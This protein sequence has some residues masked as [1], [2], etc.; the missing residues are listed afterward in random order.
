[1]HWR[2]LDREHTQAVLESVKSAAEPGLFS[3]ATSEVE[4]SLLP[5]YKEY[6]A[7][8]V[9]NYAS[10]PSFTFVYLGDGSFFHF[11]DGS[12][13]PIFAVNDKGQLNLTE[14]NVLDYLSFYFENVGLEDGEECYFIQNPQDMPLF[15]SLDDNTINAIIANHES[16]ITSF[17]PNNGVFSITA[18]LYVEGQV[19]RANIEVKQSSGRVKIIDQK[20]IWNQLFDDN[21]IESVT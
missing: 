10:L 21:L 8:K 12:V 13:D 14:K 18:E 11:M 7:F 6:K 5:F 1:M 2:R 17:D 19:N 3:P 20:M 16:P 9:T 15:D 4:S